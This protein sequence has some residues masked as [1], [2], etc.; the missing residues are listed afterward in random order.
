[1]AHEDFGDR[2]ENV[3]SA[4]TYFYEDEA[5]CDR[6]TEIFLD[7]IDAVSGTIISY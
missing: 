4:R 1:M 2:R 7:C 5:N 3:V 6:N